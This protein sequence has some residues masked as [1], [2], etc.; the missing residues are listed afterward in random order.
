MGI[1]EYWLLDIEQDS[2]LCGYTLDAADAGAGQLTEYRRLI[3][4]ADG[5]QA[6]RVLGTSLRWVED[7]LDPG[8]LAQR[9]G[10]LGARAGYSGT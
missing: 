2:P 5:G 9:V 4:A 3:V 7:S 10:A 1:G 8:V 6:S